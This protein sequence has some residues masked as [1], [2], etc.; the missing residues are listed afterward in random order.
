M[1]HYSTGHYRAI[2]WSSHVNAQSLQSS[3]HAN[4]GRRHSPGYYFPNIGTADATGGVIL[5][6]IQLMPQLLSYIQGIVET[7]SMPKIIKS[8]ALNSRQLYYRKNRK[9]ILAE[10]NRRYHEDSAYRKA[11][12]DRARARYHNDPEYARRVIERA[13][14]RYA[15]LKKRKG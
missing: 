15:D 7:T 5:D 6:E 12:R 11:T 3:A 14:K 4:P 13:K 1:D 10:A 8:P 2:G 9:R